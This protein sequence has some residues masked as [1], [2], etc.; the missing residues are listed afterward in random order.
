MGGMGRKSNKDGIQ[1][2]SK[3]QNPNVKIQ[4]NVKAQMT[5]DL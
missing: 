2:K 1:V 3:F 4:M 5:K